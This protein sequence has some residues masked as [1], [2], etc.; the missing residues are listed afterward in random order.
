MER[1]LR[2]YLSAVEFTSALIAQRLAAGASVVV[3][4]WWYRTLAFHAGMGARGPFPDMT[5][6]ALV[7]DRTYLLEACSAVRNERRQARGP[8]RSWELRADACEHLIIAHYRSYGLVPIHTDALAI[9]EVV[10]RLER[11]ICRV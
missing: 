7:P 8:R 3:E 1:R 10:D 9:G 11:E 6:R 4:S 2:F 5:Q